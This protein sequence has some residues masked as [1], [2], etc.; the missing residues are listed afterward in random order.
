MGRKRQGDCPLP[1]RHQQDGRRHGLDGGSRRRVPRAARGRHGRDPDVPRGRQGPRRAEDQRT[2]DR[3]L[4]RAEHPR[5]ADLGPGH[6]RPAVPAA[7]RL[8]RGRRR[9]TVVGRRD[10]R[11]RDQLWRRHGSGF[12]VPQ[13]LQLVRRR[14]LSRRL[15]RRLSVVEQLSQR[16]HQHQRRCQLQPSGQQLQQLQQLEPR[17]EPVPQR[18]QQVRRQVQQPVPRPEPRKEQ[19]QGSQRPRCQLEPEQAVHSRP[20]AKQRAVTRSR[21]K[22]RPEQ[23]GGR[24]DS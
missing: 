10:R 9:R 18:H 2:A 11:E 16:Q 13:R 23:A 24:Q 1:G 12:V 15:V 19:G 4:R 5:G 21:R 17:L 22:P 8:Y 3:G 14:H 6:L 20:A 7:G